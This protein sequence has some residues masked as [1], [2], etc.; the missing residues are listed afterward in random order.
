MHHL[1]PTLAHAS[2]FPH[3]GLGFCYQP[4]CGSGARH[5]DVSLP[6]KPN[7]IS[8][9][10]MFFVHVAFLS[11]TQRC[12]CNST[13]LGMQVTAQSSVLSLREQAVV[14]RG[15]QHSLASMQRHYTRNNT[16]ADAL[17]AAR[18]C[19]ATAPFSM[20]ETTHVQ[21]AA[22]DSTASKRRRSSLLYTMTN[23]SAT[24]LHICAF[25]AKLLLRLPWHAPTAPRSKPVPS[26]KLTTGARFAN[27]WPRTDTLTAG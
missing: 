3:Q 6:G 13:Y 10:A 17:E 4:R 14:G 2:L 11:S 20:Q 21:N 15:R 8:R 18:L 16:T 25:A 26:P 27:Q 23:N 7:R 5:A 12:G 19:I 24:H 1:Y 22:S 9:Y